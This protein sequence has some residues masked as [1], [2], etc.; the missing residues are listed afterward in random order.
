[1]PYLPYE[2]PG[3][4]VIL[5]LTSFLILLNGIR[6]VLDKLL[7]CGLIGEIFIGIIWG[8]PVGGTE[9]LT[10]GTQEVIQAFGYLGLVGLVYEGGLSTSMAQLRKAMLLSVSVATVGLLM[11]IALSFLLILLPFESTTGTAYPSPLAA[12][13]AGASLCSTSLGTTFSILSSSNMQ[14]TRIGVVLVGAA[15]LDDVVGLVMVNIVTTLG[16]GA[17][18][19]WPIAR[20]VIA[21]FGLLIVTLLITPFMLKPAWTSALAFLPA[22][23]RMV[24][25][26]EANEASTSKRWGLAQAAVVVCRIPH[27]TFSLSMAI[28]LVF[29]TIASYINASVLLAAFLAGGVVNYMWSL[30]ENETTTSSAM[31]IYNQYY[32]PLLDYILVPFFFVSLVTFLGGPTSIGYVHEPYE[33][34]KSTCRIIHN[35]IFNSSSENY[36]VAAL[37]PWLVRHMCVILNFAD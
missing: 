9:W 36:T 37:L 14:R 10:E 35:D 2:E 32:R 29:I 25:P 20:P 16:H 13:S 22:S 21:S 31:V 11:P 7:Y 26:R 18:G 24:E 30:P 8:L 12:F 23:G 15:M 6:Y 34:V 27:L 19:A 3:I 28:L 5:S 33:C 1:M 17:P 4:T